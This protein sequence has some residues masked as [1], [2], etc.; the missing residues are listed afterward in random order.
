MKKSRIF[1][2][3]GAL[4]LAIS[5]VF[6][7]KANKKFKAVSTAYAGSGDQIW[8]A[9]SAIFT[10]TGTGTL[11]IYAALVTSSGHE[12]ETKVALF[13]SPNGVVPLYFK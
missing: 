1:L 2:A 10:T 4:A 11:R 6:A 5:A 7:T 13:T 12:V 9:G 3:T 8:K